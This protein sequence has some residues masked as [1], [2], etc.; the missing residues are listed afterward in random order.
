MDA[1]RTPRPRLPRWL[2][3]GLCAGAPCSGSAAAAGR[4]STSTP[5]SRL[6]PPSRRRRP[7]RRRRPRRTSGRCPTPS[8]ATPLIRARCRSR[9]TT[10]WGWRSSRTPASA[11]AREKLHESELTNAQRSMGWLPDIYAGV[12]YYRHEGGIQQFRRPADRT[13]PPGRISRGLEISSEL[14]LREGDL[15]AH[16]PAAAHLAAEGRAERGQQRGADR[17]GQHLRRSADGPPRRGDGAELEKFEQKLLDRA[18]R[19]AK[20]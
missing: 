20:T 4:S 12:A 1:A 19:L 10:C 16:R 8:R 14:D 3:A 2:A 5:T 13:R 11:L 15:P 18:E 6:R 9:S 7:I 17:G